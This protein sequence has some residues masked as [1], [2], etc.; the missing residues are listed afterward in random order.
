MLLTACTESLVTPP[1]FD[2]QGHRGARGVYPENSIPGFLHALDRG[3]KTL[4]MDV[5]ITAD[6]QVVASHEP[7]LSH[8]I[9]LDQDGESISEAEETEYNIY[10][11][12]YEELS[13]FDCGSK[14]H[15]R[16]P[17]QQKLPVY[18]PLL[19]NVIQE[20]EQHAL[21]TAR[22][23]PYYN[24]EIK[25]RPQWDGLFHPPVAVYADLV[26]E[27]INSAGVTDRA[28]LQSFDKRSLRYL[29]ENWPELTLILLE[30]DSRQPAEHIRELG[31]KPAVYSCYYPKVDAALIEYCHQ[32]GMK[33]IP[34]TV[35]E[36]A[37]MERLVKLGVDGIITDYPSRAVRYQTQ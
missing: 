25:S 11:L 4:E 10:Q 34:W 21:E 1:D 9:C 32:G 7:F 19:K 14:P 22:S 35:N 33:V 17:D 36:T 24:I 23:L 30:E 20:A 3:V 12:R 6:S 28:S 15:P 31:F 8:E 5:V 16:F 2:W 26:V 37:D 27:A 13:R 18:K 29:H